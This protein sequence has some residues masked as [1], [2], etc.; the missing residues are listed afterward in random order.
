MAERAKYAE[1]FTESSRLVARE[2]GSFKWSIAYQSRSGNPRE[3][4]LGPDVGAVMEGIRANGSRYV[5]VVP[6]GFLC[7][8]VEVLYDLDIEARDMAGR[9]GLAY[10]RAQTVME[11]PSFV[12]MM[13]ALI[14]IGTDTYF[15]CKEEHKA[16]TRQEK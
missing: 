13:A 11:H 9:V 5:L 2:L 10:L 3:P 6:I 14:K 15:S 12:K 8:N 7:D 16:M 1:A 4:W